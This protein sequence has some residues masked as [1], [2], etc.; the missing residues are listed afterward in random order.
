MLD[1]VRSELHRYFGLPFY[2]AMFER[3]GFGGDV[4]AYDAVSDREEQK[5][6]ISE[7]LIEQLCALGDEAAVQAGIDRYRQAGAT[8]PV[9]TAVWGTEFEPTLRAAAHTAEE[10]RR[11]V[12]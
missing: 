3:A 1:G 8:N 7:E 12:G 11:A 6:A 5:R 2:R 4:A 10:P 9:I